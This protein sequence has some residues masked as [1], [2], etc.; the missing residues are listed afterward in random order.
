MRLFVAFMVMTLSDGV[1]AAEEP[2]VELGTSL[3][4]SLINQD[5][6]GYSHCWVSIR[7]MKGRLKEIGIEIPEEESEKMSEYMVARNRDIYE[8]YTKIQSLFDRNKIDRSTLSMVS[9][10]PSN[11]RDNE[12]P[13]GSLRKAA[14]FDVVFVDGNKTEYRFRI[15][16]GV[17]DGH[18]WYFSDSPTNLFS[19]GSI[20]SFRDNREAHN[21]ADQG[22]P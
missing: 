21:K 7:Q 22:T 1:I 19:N 6:I 15:D 10:T 20:L 12:A 18:S 2:E 8:S 16:D 14:G 9:C 13:K 5:P 17:F 4:T 3:L 11:V